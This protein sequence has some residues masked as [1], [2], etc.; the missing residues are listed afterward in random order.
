MVASFLIM[1]ILS[2]IWQTPGI[3]YNILENVCL[4]SNGQ[5]NRGID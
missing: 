4:G 3:S 5:K 1:I 2:D